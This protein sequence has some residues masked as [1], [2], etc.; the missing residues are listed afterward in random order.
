[1]K[2]ARQF[3]AAAVA[4]ATA[5]GV[6]AESYRLYNIVPMHVGHEQEQAA[7]SVEMYARTGEDLALYSLTLHPEG[8]PA[9][10]KVDRYVASYRAFAKALEGTKVRP[11]VLVQAILGHWP[12]TDK[13]IEP[14]ERT[15]DQDGKTVRFCPLDPGFAA[16]IDYVF[17]EL[18]KARPA[19]IL[20]DDDVRAYSHGAECFCATHV[21][22]FNARRGTDYTSDRLRAAVAKAKPGEPD[23]DTFMS[24]Q[25]DMMENHVA[26][27]IRAAI[28][29]VDPTIP[30]G[31][32][33]PGEEHYFCAPLARRMAAKGQVPVM[34]CATGNYCE[35]MTAAGFPDAWLRMLGFTAYYGDSGIDLLDEA[36]TCPQNLWSKGARSLMTHLVASCFTGMKG[37][38]AWYVNAI[39]ATGIPVT[40]RYTDV[41][42]ENRGF[43]DALAAEVKDTRMAGLSVPCFTNHPNWHAIGN[44]GEFL[45]DRRNGLVANVTVPFGVPVCASRDFADRSRVFVLTT[46]A[47]V[48]RL[49]DADLKVLLSGRVLVLRDAAVALTKRGFAALTGVS[50]ELKPLLFTGERDNVRGV[51]LGYSPSLSG[52]VAFTAEKG[53]ERLADFIYKPYAGALDVEVVAPSTVFFRN[54]LGG[55]VVTAAYHPS[56]FCLQQHS[57]GRKRWF[58][59]LVDRLCGGETLTVCEEDQDV[60]VAERTRPNGDR[61]VLAVNL[62]TDPIDGL[63]IRKSKGCVCEQLM[64]DGSWQAQPKGISVGFYE[65][66]VIRLTNR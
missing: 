17:T 55:Q 24:L 11:A 43:L 25:R 13:D 38:K 41:L 37:A 26:G 34:R 21:K 48:G 19:F 28:D 44:H 52:S 53:A 40:R 15:V 64:P 32:C 51:T 33:I 62:G 8:R 39:R 36:D 35:R 56:M 65:A 60:L 20:T 6:A 45:V 10:A 1:M 7:R 42:A 54:G 23:Y 12:R 22:L 46:E 61:I 31:I 58:V 66:V 30:A 63:R 59:D 16:Y 27:R 5:V 2:I 50:A 47:E 57:E 3:V 18:A 4:F 14:W 49:T 9:R 29:A